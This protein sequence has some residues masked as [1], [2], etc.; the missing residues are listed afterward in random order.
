MVH[1]KSNCDGFKDIGITSPSGTMQRDLMLD[2]YAESE[3]NPAEV[4]FIEAH[5]TGTKAGDPQEIFSIQEVFCQN[6]E[7]TLLIGSVKSN[8][9]HAEPVAAL[10]SLAKVMSI[11]YN[12]RKVD[13]LRD[14][15]R[16]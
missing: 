10:C 4:K 13:A 8:L 6:R 9:G 5:S 15:N 2:V 3:I 11:Y 7:D 12:S 14:M 16:E 1:G